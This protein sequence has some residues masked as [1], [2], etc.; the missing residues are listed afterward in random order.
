MYGVL[1]ACTPVHHVCAVP[2]EAEE[3]VRS[4]GTEVTDGYE[5]W[6]EGWESNPGL[7]ED[8]PVLLRAEAP[9]QPLHYSFDNDQFHPAHLLFWICCKDNTCPS[10]PGCIAISVHVVR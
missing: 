9:L 6:C 8:W 1:P 4:H 5:M 2:V 7:L 10:V 3:G